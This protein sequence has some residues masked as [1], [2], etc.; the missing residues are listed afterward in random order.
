MHSNKQEN[1]TYNEKNWLIKTDIYVI[2]N[3]QGH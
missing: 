1:R 2:I 3:R